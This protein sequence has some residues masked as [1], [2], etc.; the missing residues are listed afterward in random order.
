[1]LT[2]L[3]IVLALAVLTPL[4]SGLVLY[5]QFRNSPE[6]QWQSRVL[7]LLAA[8]QRRMREENQTLKRLAADEEADARALR[9][10][11][12]HSYLGDISVAE[13]DAY[14]GI[15]PGTVSKLREGGYSNLASLRRARIRISG[16]GDK[17]LADID[18]AVNDLVRK[19]HKAFDAG[20]CRQARALD[21][22]LDRAAAKYDALR[23]RA[24]A[25]S[26]AAREV[27]KR[28][29]TPAVAVGRLTF[30]SWIRPP[31]EEPIIAQE[32]LD[33]ALPNLESAL[34]EADN[35][36]RL[37]PI[38]R[39]R[40][41]SA[42][43]RT[44]PAT[45]TP[46]QRPNTPAPA[47]AKPV[48]GTRARDLAWWREQAEQVAA[49]GSTAHATEQ[50]RPQSSAQDNVHLVLMELTI[51]FALAVARAD[52]PLTPAE[53]ELIRQY[54][55]QRYRSHRAL[56]NRAEAF[57]AHYESAAI[58]L[59]NCV[60]QL[61]QRLPPAALPP[62]MELA[63]RIVGASGQGVSAAAPFL[64][65]LAQH[66]GVEVAVAAQQERPA[67]PVPPA[68]VA[69]A[70]PAAPRRPGA[71]APPAIAAAGAPTAPGVGSPDVGRNQA[72]A[73]TRDECLALLEIPASVALSADLVRRQWNL[74]SQRM[75]PEKASA[76]GP[77]AVKLA[78][79]KLAAVQRAAESLLKP[80]GEQLEAPSPARPAT[81]LRHNPDL[82]DVFGGM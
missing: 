56:L 72:A 26:K 6:A 78:E 79:R 23:V 70:A 82:D 58:D 32:I 60:H 27:L 21:T 10:E 5:V 77:E 18:H 61:R 14:T 11:A 67:R 19:A 15:G 16:L 37:A 22:E 44:S 17:R 68:P 65:E 76:W 30:W 24:I 8:A 59:D 39:S 50:P 74:L 2:V 36:A 55:R 53:R 1:V 75:A 43:E 25:R 12:F 38:P 73:P 4:I 52:G 40:E 45:A 31:S 34:R 71:P 28:L 7:N 64:R 49:S 29:K 48:E 47:K 51:Q 41:K 54:L 46:G 69:V 13:L 62:L 35:R 57:C 33:A 3:A 63:H 20:E 9:D 81:D 42:E 66:L 80:M